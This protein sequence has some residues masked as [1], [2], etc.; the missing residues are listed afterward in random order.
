VREF[1]GDELKGARIRDADL[2]GLTIRNAN[3]SNL[4]ITDSFLGGADI[5]AN[6]R[7]LRINGVEVEPL[8]EA[9][10][11]RR[12]P[13]RTKLRPR[14]LA[15]I[16]VAMD[17]VDEMWE[18][19]IARA[20]R[21]PSEKLHE[22]VGGEFSFVE[23]MRHLLFAHDAWLI[24]MVLQVPNAHHEWGVPP[25]L[26]PDAAPDT[27]PELAQVLELRAER[28]ARVRAH[29]ETV[30][31][32]DLRTMLEPPDAVGHPQRATR[33]IDCFRIAFNEEW[34]HHQY[35]TR[36]LAVLEGA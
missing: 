26:P 27:G 2:S 17:V 21:L 34:W 35:A 28:A 33:M 22:R 8:V 19:T 31:E 15:D 23:T 14:H 18:P 32:D 1:T 3:L 13:E 4:S 11:D 36:D 9:E 7:G 10:L 20:M 12:H 6:I 30:H 5:S 16:K 29:L 24:R 25:D